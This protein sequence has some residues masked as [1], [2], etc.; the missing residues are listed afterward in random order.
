LNQQLR[1][2]GVDQAARVDQAAVM[3]G[4]AARLGQAAVMVDQAAR[5]GQAVVMVLVIPG[6][7]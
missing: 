4:Q 5:L 1:I 3:V 6:S 2:P 7:R